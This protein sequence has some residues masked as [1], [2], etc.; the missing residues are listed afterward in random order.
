MAH[1]VSVVAVGGA[2]CYSTATLKTVG[3]NNN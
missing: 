2:Y 3:D 1:W